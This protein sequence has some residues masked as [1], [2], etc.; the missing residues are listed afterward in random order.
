MS[1]D[2]LDLRYPNRIAKVQQREF[3]VGKAVLFQEEKGIAQEKLDMVC[4]QP[5]RTEI[6]DFEDIGIAWEKLNS[7]PRMCTL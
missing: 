1:F 7:T 4:K 5:E 3:H 6:K 2:I